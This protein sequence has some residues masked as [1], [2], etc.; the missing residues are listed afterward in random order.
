MFYIAGLKQFNH[1]ITTTGS[2]FYTKILKAMK[3]KNLKQCVLISLFLPGFSIAGYKQQSVT[4]SVFNESTTIPYNTF[5]NTPVHPGV[6]IGTEFGRTAGKH[7]RLYPSVNVGYMFH[8]RL[9]QGLYANAE[10]GL[11]YKT[12]FGIN[13]KSKI[14]LGYLHTF[15]TQQEYRFHNG[16][17]SGGPDGGLLSNAYD[18]NIFMTRLFSGQVLTEPSMNELL[19]RQAPGE[20]PGDAFETFYGLGILKLTTGFGPA[21]MH[22]GYAIGYF[23]SMLYFPEQKT[24]IT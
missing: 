13:L 19:S 22:S 15:T 6:Q 8:R 21:W 7:L 5:F 1:N 23:A 17:Y 16:K 2:C 18:L 9:F 24:T 10:I 14:G 4:V 12:A 3:H 20:Q 11:D